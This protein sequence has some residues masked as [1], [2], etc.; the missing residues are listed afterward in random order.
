M[1]TG[2]PDN[3]LLTHIHDMRIVP[4][5]AALRVREAEPRGVEEHEAAHVEFIRETA[6]GGFVVE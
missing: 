3:H 1:R 5:G 2:P 4:C 6:I